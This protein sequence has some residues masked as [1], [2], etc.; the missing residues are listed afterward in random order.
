LLPSVPRL[1]TIRVKLPKSFL[2]VNLSESHTFHKK[3]ELEEKAEDIP[4]AGIT[5][6]VEPSEQPLTVKDPTEELV[7]NDPNL[8][9]LQKPNP[10]HPSSDHLL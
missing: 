7:M 4:V 6:Q 8:Q 1:T 5:D 9:L 3:E 10:T 2:A